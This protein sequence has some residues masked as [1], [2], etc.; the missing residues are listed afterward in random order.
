MDSPQAVFY[1][2]ED[3]DPDEGVLYEKICGTF[4]KIYLEKEILGEGTMG[5]VKKFVHKE[6]VCPNYATQSY[7]L[8]LKF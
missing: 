2:K 8:I 7:Y 5:L 3:V 4:K 1:H 6:T